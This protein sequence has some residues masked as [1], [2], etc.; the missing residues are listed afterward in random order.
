MN[1]VSDERKSMNKPKKLLK[2]VSDELESMNKH[3]QVLSVN[4]HRKHFLVVN[5]NGSAWEPCFVVVVE[6]SGSSADSI[7]HFF[8]QSDAI[9][10]CEWR[11]RGGK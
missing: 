6:G 1:Q 9:D 2:V 11:N 5:R 10:Y 7:A 8:T 4:K 3:K